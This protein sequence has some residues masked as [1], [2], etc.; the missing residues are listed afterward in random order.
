MRIR[1]FMDAAESVGA[2]GYV[3]KHNLLTHLVGALRHAL[4]Q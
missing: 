4:R 1:D 3:L 2:S